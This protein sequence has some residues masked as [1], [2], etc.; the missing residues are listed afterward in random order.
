[1]SQTEVSIVQKCHFRLHDDNLGSL[2]SLQLLWPLFSCFAS[3][4]KINDEKYLIK[5]CFFVS[6]EL[7]YAF[8]LGFFIDFVLK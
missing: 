8:L 7:A 4:P 1:M 6:M 3:K 5:H 2:I